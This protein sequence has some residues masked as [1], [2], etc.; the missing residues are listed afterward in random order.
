MDKL[1]IL[2][3]GSY[4]PYDKLDYVTKVSSVVDYPGIK[5]QENIVTGLQKYAE[6]KSINVPLIRTCIGFNSIIKGYSFTLGDVNDNISVGYL[7]IIG[8]KQ[9]TSLYGS[10]KHFRRMKF[11]PDIILIYSMSSDSFILAD[12]IRKE[13]KNSRIVP[14]ITD[15]PFNM[16]M[17]GGRIY[18]FLKTVENSILMHYFKKFNGYIL[19]SEYMTE[20]LPVNGKKYEIVE[21]IYGED[22]IAPDVTNNDTKTI[23]YIGNMSNAYGVKTLIEA[24]MLIKRDNYQLLL[25]GE[26]SDAEYLDSVCKKDNRIKVLPR[27]SREEILRYERNATLL[28]NPVPP[29]LPLTRYFFPSKTM[30]YLAS[31]TPT[32]MY[33]LDCIPAEYDKYINY[34]KTE[35]VDD[36]YKSMVEI[37]EKPAEDLNKKGQEAA[38]F[39]KMK[40][41]K[42]V[43]TFK[44]FN[45]LQI[46]S[47]G[48]C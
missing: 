47:N 26:G 37:C 40:K 29:S 33:H 18:K 1:K 36:M 34:I 8:F 44:I 38:Q 31:G 27:L 48:L 12:K 45:F 24:F 13:S 23:L 22:I 20:K 6:V 25:R 3:L 35:S 4:I 10:L 30:E 2:F 7:N 21:G 11:I 43:Q 39:I 28:V 46:V 5:L 19:L 17:N 15:L 32:L 9:I 16:D 42:E 14:I 41:N